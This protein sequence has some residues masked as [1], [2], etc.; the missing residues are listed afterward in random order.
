MPGS[1]A[2][3]KNRAWKGLVG[4]VK[5]ALAMIAKVAKSSYDNS[6]IEIIRD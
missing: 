3:E 4:M 6:E 2:N 1:A 5:N